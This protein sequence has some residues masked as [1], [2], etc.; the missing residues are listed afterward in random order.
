MLRYVFDMNCVRTCVVCEATATS[1]HAATP[2]VAAST[3]VAVATA[4]V[5]PSPAHRAMMYPSRKKIPGVSL[6]ADNLFVA[7]F[8]KSRFDDWFAYARLRP[9]V[10]S[11]VGFFNLCSHCLFVSFCL[12][13]SL[14]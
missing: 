3:L 11:I 2:S 12:F 14:M 6:P 4:V 8:S 9:D 1:V 13:L 10:A 5:A 7:P